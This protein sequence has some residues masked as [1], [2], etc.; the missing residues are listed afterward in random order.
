MKSHKYINPWNPR[1]LA[2]L[3]ETMKDVF[4]K[5]NKPI[6][7]YVCEV[8]ETR[9]LTQN[10]YYWSLMEM[11][12]KETGDHRNEVH[13]F[14]KSKFLGKEEITI[15]GFKETAE[16]STTDLDTK[17]MTDYIDNI[18]KFALDFLGIE[19]PRPGEV[20][21]EIYIETVNR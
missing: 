16:T 17:Q 1:H 5:K 12:G 3:E 18:I 11:I 10:R 4:K 21:I 9:T 2:Q 15:G 7:V 8:T 6:N 13:K 20:P 19:L 14:M